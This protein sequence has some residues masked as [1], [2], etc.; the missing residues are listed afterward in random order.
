MKPMRNAYTETAAAQRYD[1][2][3]SLPSETK[4]VW[5]EAVR[6][7]IPDGTIK[8]VLD[9]G[10]G[11][12]RFTS[13]LAET[14]GCPAVGVEPSRA[15]LDIALARGGANVQWKQGDA[16]NI[17]LEDHSVDLVFMSQVFHHL[18]DPKR[19][20]DE[21]KRILTPRGYLVIRNGTR[22]HNP[23]LHWLRFFPEAWKIEDARTPFSR[24][25]NAAVTRQHFVLI[26]HQTIHQLFAA[27]Y[28]EYF[29]KISRRGLSALIAISD[30]DFYNGREKF[31]RWVNQQPQDEAVYEPVDLFIFQRG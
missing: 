3:R 16:G 14:F 5:L 30:K 6:S 13:A 26:S 31:K 27:S 22:E 21:C 28:A 19:A 1:S 23:E 25:I 10:C 2:A 20:L 29:E 18:P 4:S 8:R 12:G 15:M 24:E 9:L 11:T 17:P 7:A